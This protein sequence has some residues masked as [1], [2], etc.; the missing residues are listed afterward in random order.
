MAAQSHLIQ[1]A[2]DAALKVRH[3]AWAP[4]SKFLVGAAIVTESGQIYTGVNVENSSFGGTVC[5]ERI[6]VFHALT[7]G[8][9]RFDFLI[10]ASDLKGHAAYP[11]GMCRQILAD[12]GSDISVFVVNSSNGQI[13]AQCTVA[14][15]L[16]HTFQF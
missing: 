13:E 14:D 5:A 8:E 1:P 16:P 12:F 11:C 7:H 6:A 2:I 9:S 3:H 10:V 4:Y 15:L